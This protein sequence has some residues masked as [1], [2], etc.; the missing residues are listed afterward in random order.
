[1]QS[2]MLCGDC[3]ANVFYV[4]CSSLVEACSSGDILTVKKLLDEGR[5]VNEVTEEGESLLSLACSSGYYE[6]AQV[7]S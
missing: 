5:D 3:Y 6:L 7:S 1:M 2:N 4:C